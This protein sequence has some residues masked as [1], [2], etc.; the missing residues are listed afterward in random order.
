[1]NDMHFLNNHLSADTT[2]KS[3]EP[4]LSHFIKSFFSEYD[5]TFGLTI[6]SKIF[7]YKIFREEIT[8]SKCLMVNK[9]PSILPGI[10]LIML[11]ENNNNCIYIRFLVTLGVLKLEESWVLTGAQVSF[12]NLLVVPPASISSFRWIGKYLEIFIFKNELIVL[13]LFEGFRHSGDW[14]G[15]F[16]NFTFLNADFICVCKLILSEKIKIS[17]FRI[18]IPFSALANGLVD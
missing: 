9:S 10:S 3:N 7:L 5:T 16:Y 6:P 2:H 11:P 12:E 17:T 4:D 13:V 15:I 14:T 18:V 1:M 8:L